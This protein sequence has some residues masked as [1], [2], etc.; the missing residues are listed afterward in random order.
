MATDPRPAADAEV[1]RYRRC[2]GQLST[3]IGPGT[4][5]HEREDAMAQP[6]KVGRSG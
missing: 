3:Q 1:R 6:R 2:T 5:E 4:E